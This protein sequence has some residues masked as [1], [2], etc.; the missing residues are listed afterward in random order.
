MNIIPLSVVT[1]TNIEILGAIVS[2]LEEE[3]ET[4]T[5]NINAIDQI[6]RA[7]S[8]DIIPHIQDL[9]NKFQESAKYEPANSNH[10]KKKVSK[11]V[12]KLYQR[13]AKLTH[14]D[15]VSENIRDRMKDI[16]LKGVVAYEN[17][18]SAVLKLLL[19]EASK[20][21]VLSHLTKMDV[22]NTLDFR[23]LEDLKRSKSDLEKKLEEIK[24]CALYTVLQLHESGKYDEALLV[25]RMNLAHQYNHMRSSL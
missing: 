17:N 24:S 14:P 8:P 1:K 13:L 25:H 2:R 22:D 6:Y 20:L 16:F 11:A 12:K 7:R 9:S 15:K 19:D 5:S 21:S 23:I 10:K 3:H 18:N 4:I